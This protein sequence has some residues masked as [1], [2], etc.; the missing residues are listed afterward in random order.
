MIVDIECHYCGG[1]VDADYVLENDEVVCP[2]CKKLLVGTQEDM[3]R[4]IYDDLLDPTDPAGYFNNF[5]PEDD[6]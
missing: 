2:H 5:P 3:N 1:K 4:Q 6:F